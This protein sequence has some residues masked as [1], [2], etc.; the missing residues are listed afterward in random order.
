MRAQDRAPTTPTTPTT[1]TAPTLRFACIADAVLALAGLSVATALVLGHFGRTALPGCGLDSPCARAA[2]SAWATVPGLGWPVAGVAGA[3]FVARLGVVVTGTP[4]AGIVRWVDRLAAAVAILYIAVAFQTGLW[5][6]YCLVSHAATIGLWIRSEFFRPAGAPVRPSRMAAPAIAGVGVIAAVA[7]AT[8]I[9]A[10]SKARDAAEAA[11]KAH[12]ELSTPTTTNPKRPPGRYLSGSAA[13]P[14]QIVVFTGYQCPDCYKLE[15]ALAP[16]MAQPDIS[17]SIR[18]FPFGTDCNRLAKS[19]TQPNGC[20]AARAAE[21]AGIVG[22]VE[23]FWAMHRWLFERRGAFTDAELGAYL[24]GSPFD[25]KAFIAAMQSEATLAIVRADVDEAAALA[26]NRTPTVFINNVEIQI[27][28]AAGALPAAVDAARKGARAEQPMTGV[29]RVIEE[30]RASPVAAPQPDR[31]PHRMGEDAAP[32]EI[33]VFGDYQD[34]GTVELD[35]TLRTL[36]AK[37]PRVKYAYR[38]FPA[39]QKCNPKL[40]RSFHPLACRFARTA[41]AAG[42]LHGEEGFWA[43]HTWILSRHRTYTDAD[44]RAFCADKGWDGAAIL[45]ARDGADPSAAVSE[46]VDA[47]QAIGVTELPWILVNGKRLTRWKVES[48]DVF[49]RLLDAAR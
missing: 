6:A 27:W 9:A 14:I 23:G 31:V 5:C 4:H 42:A 40:P 8:P 33:V 15:A 20:W 10:A 3:Y 35:A 12:R 17:V 39:D 11:A 26:L 19:T 44:L 1:P 38:H 30:W 2:G 22:G 28:D 48:G 13:A 32:V 45:K 46:D 49:D 24:A 43:V 47:G 18:H 34:D 37:D 21:A 36:T 7:I 16:F 41:E 25:P 29:D